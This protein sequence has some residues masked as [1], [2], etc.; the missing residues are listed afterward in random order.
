M[1]DTTFSKNLSYWDLDLQCIS[2]SLKPF[3]N[4]FFLFLCICYANYKVLQQSQKNPHN[5]KQFK[6]K[7]WPTFI[8]L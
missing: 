8:I 3:M 1:L 5:T 6:N 2:C 4:F 7:I